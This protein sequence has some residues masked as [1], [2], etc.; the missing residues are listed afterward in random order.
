MIENVLGLEVNLPR[1][2]IDWTI[3]NIEEMGIQNISLKKNMIRKI[4]TEKTNRGWEIKIENE[5]LYY[6]ALKI[7][8]QNKDK[9]LP[10]PSGTCS[11]L[12]EKL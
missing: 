8:D 7:L 6:F 2:T 9:R 4:T 11:M 12:I 10:I 3:S 1:K 5:K